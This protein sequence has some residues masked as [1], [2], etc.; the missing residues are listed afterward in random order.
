MKKTQLLL[1][2]FGVSSEICAPNK[3]LPFENIPFEGT[4]N[5]VTERERFS[6]EATADELEEVRRQA[7]G[8]E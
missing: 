6:R 7:G 1:L 4:A 5:M 3:N 2:F 8:T